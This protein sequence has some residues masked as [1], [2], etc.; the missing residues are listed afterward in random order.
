M[1]D[2][3]PPIHV[4]LMRTDQLIERLQRVMSYLATGQTEEAAIAV[5]ALIKDASEAPQV[6]ATKG[7]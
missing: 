1:S 4:S 6:Y 3:T 7:Q 2:D 5:A